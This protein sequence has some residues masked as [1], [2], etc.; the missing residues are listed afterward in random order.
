M[1]YLIS[2]KIKTYLKIISIKYEN[3]NILKLFIKYSL[4]SR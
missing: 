4:L 3:K 1:E 2:K